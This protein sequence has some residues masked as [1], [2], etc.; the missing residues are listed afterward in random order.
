MPARKGIRWSESEAQNFAKI[1][2]KKHLP[3]V[4]TEN[5]ISQGE[6]FVSMSMDSLRAR[7]HAEISDLSVGTGSVP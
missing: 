1:L 7:S 4:L 2:N 5:K 3:V 6:E